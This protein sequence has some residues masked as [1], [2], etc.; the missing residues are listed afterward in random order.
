MK[1]SG[2]KVTSK[3]GLSEWEILLNQWISL[4]N[5]YCDAFSGKDAPYYYNERANIGVLSGAAWTIGWLSLEEFQHEKKTREKWL[6][7]ADLYLSSEKDEFYVEA[8][9]RPVSLESRDGIVEITNESIKLAIKDSK[10]TR[11]TIGGGSVVAA[12]FIP[13]YLSVN[14]LETMDEKVSKA[15]EKMMS[16]NFHGLAWTFPQEMKKSNINDYIYP[17]IF[18]AVVNEKYI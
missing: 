9:Y 11:R 4:T 7:R 12:A 18:L 1:P 3:K 16:A 15:I 10:A 6:G 14:K 8:K 5:K 17:G 2:V 13:V